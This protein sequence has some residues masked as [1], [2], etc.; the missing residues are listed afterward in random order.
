MLTNDFSLN[1]FKS[2]L[3]SYDNSTTKWMMKLSSDSD[4][5]ATT[6]GSLPPFGTKEYFLSKELGGGHIT[7]NVNACDDKTE[8]NCQD[9]SCILME[10]R[11][12]S[13]FDCIDASDEIECNVIDIP[14][15]YLK[16][17]PGI[18]RSS[19]Y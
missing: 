9:G 8:Y 7:L 1:G 19:A 2:T 3:I 4:K 6:N 13:Q 11:C 15:A 17:V 16:H 12:D 5:Y 18:I 10:H 14:V